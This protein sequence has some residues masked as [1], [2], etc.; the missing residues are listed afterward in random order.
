MF[1]SAPVEVLGTQL[2]DNMNPARDPNQL[3]SGESVS[4]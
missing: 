1:S 4:E 3:S 2:N